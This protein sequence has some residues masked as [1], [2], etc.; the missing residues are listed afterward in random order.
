MRKYMS[1]SLSGIATVE[2]ALE[3]EAGSAVCLCR[4]ALPSIA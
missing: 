3:A 1:Y 4:G 2:G